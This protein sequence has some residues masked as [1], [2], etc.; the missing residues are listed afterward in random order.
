MSDDAQP[1]HYQETT[2]TCTWGELP[3]DLFP[4]ETW[5]RTAG[6]WRLPYCGNRLIP[7]PVPCTGTFIDFV[8]QLPLGNVNSFK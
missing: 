3:E 7:R 4:V 5:P 8:Q 2:F 1:M 6:Q